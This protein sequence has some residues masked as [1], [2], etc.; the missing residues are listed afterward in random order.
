MARSLLPSI[1]RRGERSLPNAEYPLFSLHRE[2]DRMFDDVSRRFHLSLFD[3]F[4]D[5]GEFNPSVDVQEDRKGMHIK[6][7]LPGVDEKDVEVTVTG[8]SLRIKGEKKEETEEKGE[9]GYRLHE[10]R[11]GSFDRVLTLPEGVNSEKVEAHFKNGVLNVEIPW[12]DG[13][14]AKLKSKKIAIKAE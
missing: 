9:E 14:K 3:D 6:A 12:M 13:E 10:S 8:N 7:E 1:W 11:Y 2:I 5:M 4:R